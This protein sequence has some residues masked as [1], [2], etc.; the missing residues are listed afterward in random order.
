M[1][2]SL[3]VK[4]IFFSVVIAFAVGIVATVFVFFIT[5][6]IQIENRHDFLEQLTNQ[7]VKEIRQVF[8]QGEDIVATIA[9]QPTILEPLVNGI[10]LQD[11][12]VLQ[13]LQHFDIGGR[14]SSIYL[15]APDGTT[16]VSTDPSFVGNNYGFREYFQKALNGR[17]SVD[18]VRGVTSG[19]LGYY[20]SHPILHE[21]EVIAV[22]VAKMTPDT[23]HDFIVF[24]DSLDEAHIMFVE[25][26]GV[27]VHTDQDNRLYHSLGS[28]DDT[29]KKN[30]TEKRRFDGLDIAPLQYDIVQQNLNSISETTLIDFHDDFDGALEILSVSQIGELPFWIVI[31]QEVEALLAPVNRVAFVLGVI[32]FIASVMGGVFISLFIASVLKPLPILYN[33]ARRISQGDYDT[34]VTGILGSYEFEKLAL[35][36]NQMMDGIKQ[37]RKEVDVKVAKQTKEIVSRQ[38]EMEDQ[39][40]AILN[41][42][43]DVEDEKNKNEII[44]RDLEKFKMAVDDTSDHVVITDSEGIILYANDAVERITGFSPDEILGTKVGTKE[45]WGGQMEEEFYENLWNTI[46]EKKRAFRGDVNNRRKSGE[47]YQSYASISPILDEE[48][49]NVQFFVGIE[50]DVTKERQID[51]AKTEFVSLASHQLRTPLST[52]NWYAEMLLNGDAGD[53]EPEQANYVEEIYRGNQRMVGLVNSLLNVSRLELGTFMIEPKLVDIRKIADSAFEEIS[54]KV[55]EKKQKFSKKYARGLKKM[56]LDEKLTFMIFQN[57]LSNAIKYTP[58]KGKISLEIKKHTKDIEI[59]ITDNGMGIPK[60]QHDQIFTKLFRADNV[61]ESDT[62]GTGL[63]L[64][65]IKSI[66]DHVGGTIHFDSAKDKGTTFFVTIPITGMKAK[67]GTR[68]LS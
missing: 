59:I 13:H 21:G 42:L 34:K 53:M 20:F 66:L 9:K 61:R 43:E 46:K 19:Q 39:Q 2:L 47:V 28:L 22:A 45:N 3:K 32:V 56:E 40:R 14:Y 29:S 1:K 5:R 52:I 51:Q 65:V 57:L 31:E 8:F 7:I 11:P 35:S 60:N 23:I 27:I 17:P 36:F 49:N 50:R 44:A 58:E 12:H 63:G 48:D 37:S 33:A 62:E 15:I 25:E 18:V 6:N 55:F 67:K 68:E 10:E 64:Y 26:N 54:H 16:L 38:Q 30:I 4:T 41:I 24:D